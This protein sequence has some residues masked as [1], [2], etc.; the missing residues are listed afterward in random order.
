MWSLPIFKV[1]ATNLF[2]LK[3]KQKTSASQTEDICR[4]SICNFYD[5]SQKWGW[6]VQVLENFLA[7]YPG[8]RR[9]KCWKQRWPRGQWHQQP[10]LTAA[11]GP[12]QP[13]LEARNEPSP[14]ESKPHNHELSQSTN[15][16]WGPAVCPALIQT[17]TKQQ[18]AKQT[19]SLLYRSTRTCPLCGE[20]EKWG[21]FQ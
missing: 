16:H 2:H 17:P 10:G 14:L 13:S 15:I 11:Q 12:K 20:N 3:T 1:L 8:V 9:Q 5:G 18:W 7:S 19:Q 6:G 21:S 4:P